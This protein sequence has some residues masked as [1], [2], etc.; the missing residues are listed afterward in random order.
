MISGT[1]HDVWKI[2]VSSMMYENEQNKNKTV[3]DRSRLILII[4]RLRQLEAL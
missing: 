4:I 2:G 3:K 1:Y